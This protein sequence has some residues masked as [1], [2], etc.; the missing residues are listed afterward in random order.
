[1]GKKITD[2][3]TLLLIASLPMFY[4]TFLNKWTQQRQKRLIRIYTRVFSSWHRCLAL[5]QKVSQ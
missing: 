3:I 5:E 4:F 1:M 2:L